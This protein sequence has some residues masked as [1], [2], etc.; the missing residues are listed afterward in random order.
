MGGQWFFYIYDKRKQT[1][2]EFSYLQ[3]L[4]RRTQIELPSASANSFFSKG[5]FSIIMKCDDGR[6]AVKVS[7]ADVVLLDAVLDS[8]SS[9]A[10]PFCC[11]TGATG[12]TYTQK[13]TMQKVTGRYVLDG[14]SVDISDAGGYLAATDDSC[15]FFRYKTS[16]H[17]LSLS[18]RV[19]SGQTVGINFTLGANDGFGTDNTIWI[20]GAAHE[21]PA[22]M[23]ELV[24][25]RMD[26]GVWRVYSAD[27]S[28][29][30]TVTTSWS[31]RES[32]NF[33]VAASHF[34]QWV[35]Q[36]R[37]RI[38]CTSQVLEFG[39]EM[40]LLEKHFAKW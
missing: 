3:P 5:D 13:Q 6:R 24:E 9:E 11:P 4:A 32:L 33:F 37:G 31:R 7:K 21:M 17:W 39:G 15:G 35:S 12:W 38:V 36:V 30:L 22:V 23:F 19:S 14:L 27:G 1:V 2:V 34:N 29:N 28:V 10:M 26:S 16:W 8:S 40:A 25:Q 18:A 20:D